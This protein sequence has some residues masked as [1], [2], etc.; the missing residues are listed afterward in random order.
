[1]ILNMYDFLNHFSVLRLNAK[2]LPKNR[3][4]FEFYKTFEDVLNI[5]VE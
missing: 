1:M 3:H 5:G 4:W 2:I